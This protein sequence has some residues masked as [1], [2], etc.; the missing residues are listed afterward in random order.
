GVVVHSAA[1]PLG[2]FACSN[3]L[4]NRIHELVRWA[5]RSNMVSVLTDCPHRE[6]LGWLEQYHLNGPAIRYEFDVARIFTKGMRDMADSQLASG[7]VPN[8]APE[9]VEF[10]GT[11]RAAAEWG[12]AAI[13]VPWQ[14]Y[15]FTGDATLL[16]DY[17]DVMD[18]YMAYL[19]SRAVDGIVDEGLGDW[20]DL[21]PAERPGAA[22]LT[23]PEVTATAFYFHDA[24]IMSQ[25]AQLLDR[26]ED[27]ERYRVLASE[28]RK[29][30]L[31]K[32][33]REP[34]RY[35]TGSQCSQAIALEFGLA[36]PEDR[37]KA[38]KL[39]VDDVESRGD[40]MTAGDVGFRYLLQALAHGGRSDVIY[41]MI[42]QDEKPGYGYQ[43]KKGAT[44]LTEAW[45]ANHR[46]SHN[47][48][49]LG[50]IVEWF[51]EDLLGIDVD[52]EGPGFSKILLEPTPLGDLTW[53]EGSYESPFGPIELRWER[54]ATQFIVKATIPP[55]ASATLRMP[56][57]SGEATLDG[58]PLTD[59][60]GVVRK[61]SSDPRQVVLAFP[62]GSYV[63][64][65]TLEA[66]K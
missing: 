20:Y 65:T 8:I 57:S 59:A 39:L 7:L 15:Q 58:R 49:M 53:A 2:E 66:S 38:L 41:R 45:D 12:S 34:G 42:N 16:R 5:Q 18:K 37:A 50:H 51:Y 9:Y 24:A 32:F 6:K 3:D 11:F 13:L 35:A 62:S 63:F 27:A 4:L 40:A 60:N 48:F 1:R 19:A 64:A 17:W 22:Q 44:S 21:G 28:L 31:A 56:S 47:H 52:P 29:A 61:L 55:N 33:C 43:L 36:E 30:W 26:K 10:P 23:P 54:E 25:I 46:A 14:Q